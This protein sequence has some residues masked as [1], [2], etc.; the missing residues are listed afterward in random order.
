MLFRS[1]T[2]QL[3][4]RE[5][6]RESGDSMRIGRCVIDA[7]WGPSSDTVYQFCRQSAHAAILLPSHG[8]Y[9][10]ASATPL[11]QYTPKPG[12]RVGSGWR[13]GNLAGKRAIRHLTYDTN[14]WKS[15]VAARWRTTVGDRGAWTAFGDKPERHRL[16][17]EH[18]TAEVPVKTEA[19]GRTVDEW[20]VRPGRENHWLDCVVGAA[21]A[22]SISGASLLEGSAQPRRRVKLSDMKRG[23]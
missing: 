7:N 20:R 17:A 4:G 16:F 1:L 10:G 11:N 13:I 2:A 14:A 22:A 8:R 18:L 15:F 5:W 23:R 21:V 6:P 3:L 9:Y 19:R 12:E